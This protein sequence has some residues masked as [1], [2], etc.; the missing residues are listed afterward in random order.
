MPSSQTLWRN[1]HSRGNGVA[2]T[3]IASKMHSDRRHISFLDPLRGVAI[4]LVFVL[5]CLGAA[6]GYDELNWN[7]WFRDFHF[8][9]AFLALLPAT[10]GWVGVPIFFVISGFCIHLTYERSTRKSFSDFFLRRFFR[11]YPPYL[12]AL[13]I[14][15]FFTPWQAINF[16]S[17]HDLAQ[18][19]SHFLLVHNLD[20]RSFFGINPAFWSIAVESQLYL[21][22]PLVFISAT[23]LGWKRVLWM[24]GIIE[25][26]MR[27]F[28]GI[29]ILTRGD[30]PPV[31]FTASPFIYWFSWSIGAAMA[32]SLLNGTEFPFGKRH[33]FLWLTLL[34]AANFIRPVA[35]FCFLFASLFTASFIAFLFEHSKNSYGFQLPQ[36]V[37]NHL[38]ATGL[39]SYS[40]YL[41]HLPIIGIIPLALRKI[42]PESH[43]SPMLMFVCC[44]FSWVPILLVSWGFY[45]TVELPSIDFAKRIIQ[46]KRMTEKQDPVAEGILG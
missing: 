42:F 25:V 14:F 37:C 5:H 30:V 36:H 45:R 27:V 24:A 31:W 34:L 33:L 44:L 8:S 41:I 2:Q 10:F 40:V 16:G 29:W 13:L 15:S 38:R 18:F 9:K 11:I 19:G 6:F 22:Y 21:L 4:A 26:G 43:F 39:I 7:G 1:P 28:S 20:A 32:E 46:K 17:L 35:P 23:K 3:H 12:I